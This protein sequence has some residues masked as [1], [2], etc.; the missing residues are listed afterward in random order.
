MRQP[1]Y[2]RLLEVSASP[3]A[4]V[5][6]ALISF[7]ESSFF[8]IPPD[9]LLIP[10]C[11]VQPEKT[12]RLATICTLS[13][14]IGG[15]FG[16]FIGYYLFAE[17]GRPILTLY[18][19]GDAFHAFESLYL[20]YGV[21]MIFIKILVPIPY[22]IVSIASGKISFNFFLFVIASLITRG[23]RFFVFAGLTYILGPILRALIE[24]RPTLVMLAIGV[25]IVA[26]FVILR[27]VL[28]AL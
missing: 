6:L 17:V 11:L 16:Y 12:W 22:K 18:D 20:T 19:Y 21:K 13:S 23:V 5:W 7:S 8:P 27:Y 26:S 24:R 1:V 14:V 2:E 25:I 9:L 10:M 4:L 3:G 15:M 28:S